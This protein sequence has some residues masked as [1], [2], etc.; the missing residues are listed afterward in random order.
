MDMIERMG[1]GKRK[2]G[3]N[4]KWRGRGNNIVNEKMIML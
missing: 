1:R 3:R 4:G 2:K